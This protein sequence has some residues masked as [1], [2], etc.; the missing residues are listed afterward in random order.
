[1]S[2]RKKL[3]KIFAYNLQRGEE[4]LFYEV[5]SYVLSNNFLEISSEF[6]SKL[7]YS[8]CLDTLKSCPDVLQ[9]ISFGS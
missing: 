7:K 5:K 2:C 3:S 8:T 1:M 4:N 9:I 6:S